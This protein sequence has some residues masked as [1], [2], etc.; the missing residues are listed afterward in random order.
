MVTVVTIVMLHNGNAAAVAVAVAV[1]GVVLVCGRV[2]VDRG[3]VAAVAAVA[4]HRSAAV[5]PAQ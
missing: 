3:V 2:V 5:T 1:V 4:A